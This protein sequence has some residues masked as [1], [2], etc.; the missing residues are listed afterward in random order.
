MRVLWAMSFVVGSAGVGVAL[1]MMQVRSALEAWWQLAS[2]L[3][4]GMLGL[5]LLGFIS[6]KANSSAALA[7]VVAG[8][9]VIFWISLPKLV[10]I[11][12]VWRSHLNPFLAIVAGTLTIFAVGMTITRISSRLLSKR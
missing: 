1:A 10:D 12:P 4:G 5:F 2:I 7:G 6:R 11:P 8:V 3:G 9:L